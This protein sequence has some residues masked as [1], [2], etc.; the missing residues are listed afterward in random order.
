[1]FNID[2][3]QEILDT[4]W[5]NKLRSM[6]TAFSMAWGIF[7]LVLLLGLGNGLSNGVQQGFADDATNSVWIFT[8]T[9]SKPHEGM[10]LGRR[11]VLANR[12]IDRAHQVSEIDHLTGRFS[13]N[14]AAGLDPKVSA[15][16]KAKSF[17]VRAVHP[18]HLYLE[19]TIMVYGRFLNEPDIEQRAKVVVIGVE[20]AKFLFDEESVVGRWLKIGSVA[21]QIV[22][23]FT[24][25]GGEG[26]SAKVYIPISTAQSAYS[27]G[28][29]VNAMLFT[30]GD[31]SVEETERIVDKVRGQLAQSHKFDPEDK[32][33]L[34][35]RNSVEQF[36][37]FQAIFNMISL[38]VWVMGAGTIV[39]G[40]VGI[41]NIMMIVV[42]E[43]T[44][45]IGIR[46]A[47]GAQPSHI[48]GSVVQEA[49]A[50]TAAAGYLGLC[51]GV[52]LLALISSVIPKN[53][54][55]AEPSIDLK[56]ALAATAVLMISGTL[57]GLFPALA[58]AKV[59]PI[60]ALRDEG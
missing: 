24:D 5:R 26:E 40:V 27:G 3:W 7:M 2:R 19:R 37:R 47:L 56:V 51:S 39:A 34:R 31:A 41:S 50:L 16:N 33:A 48:I 12:D 36:Q 4:L 20:V 46:K 22:G 21:Y 49:V 53:E 23:V 42:R 32:Q 43:R 10:P 18:D 44:K 11:V 55:F 45:E 35:I 25:D 15:G 6:L 13:L 30:V 57:A 1:M 38:F 58:A 28:D 54:M 52:G 60:V 29:R 17:D 14:N 59:N 8:G 9:T